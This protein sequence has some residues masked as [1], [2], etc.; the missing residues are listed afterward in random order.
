M[1]RWIGIDAKWGVAGLTASAGVA[2]WVEFSLLRHTLNRRIGRTGLPFGLV[3]RLW[4]AAALAA[5]AGWGVK[6]A[7]GPHLPKLS[8]VPI[9]GA[10]GLVYFGATYVLG[11]E[12]CVTTL[13]RFL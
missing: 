13:Q 8:A 3:A 4:L 1:P 6:L 7:I 10:Y 2:G 9:L 11:V 12:E 5:T